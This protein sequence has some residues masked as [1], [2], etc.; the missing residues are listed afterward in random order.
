[1]IVFAKAS[2]EMV[3]N[4]GAGAGCIFDFQAST[5]TITGMTQALDAATNTIQVTVEGT[6]FTPGDLANT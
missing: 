6:G 3:C 2:E 4:I 5:T 1:M